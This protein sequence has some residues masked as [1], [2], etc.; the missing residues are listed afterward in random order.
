MTSQNRR[1]RNN[2]NNGGGSKN[3]TTSQNNNSGSR[4]CPKQMEFSNQL[5]D[6]NRRGGYTFEKITQEVLL[7]IQTT[8]QG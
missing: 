7:K 1:S 6:G 4:K 3:K 5:H 8:F 2:I